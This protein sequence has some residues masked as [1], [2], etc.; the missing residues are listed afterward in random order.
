MQDHLNLFNDANIEY[1]ANLQIA[2]QNAQ[3]SQ[4]DDSQKLQ[5]Y[6]SE[7]QSYQAD[8]N[9]EIQEY[10]QNLEGDLK[11]WQSER[12]TDIQKFSA[13]MQNAVNLFNKENVIYQATVQ[14]KIQE[15][16]LSDSN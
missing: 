14:E 15:A 16:Q 5:K 9:K 7:I 11:V 8:I 1:Q 6:S 12:Q 2:I 13:D 4:T 10:Q 3:L